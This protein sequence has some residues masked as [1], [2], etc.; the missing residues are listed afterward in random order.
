VGAST[1]LS[2]L[3]SVPPRGWVKHTD[4]LGDFIYTPPGLSGMDYWPQ[5]GVRAGRAR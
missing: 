1:S 5:I 4:R 2:P 3:T